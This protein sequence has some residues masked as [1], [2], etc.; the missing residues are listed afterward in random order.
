MIKNSKNVLQK[1]D[2]ELYKFCCIDISIKRFISKH[3]FVKLKTN[4]GVKVEEII[5]EF[6][7]IA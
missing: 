4:S 5:D 2:F 6:T 3:S 1:F 7:S